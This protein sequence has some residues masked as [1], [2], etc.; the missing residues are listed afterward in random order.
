MV[1]TARLPLPLTFKAGMAVV[2]AAA[3]PLSCTVPPLKVRLP[4]PNGLVVVS[5]VPIKLPAVTVVPPV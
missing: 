3:M 2:V 1:L 4:R 5:A